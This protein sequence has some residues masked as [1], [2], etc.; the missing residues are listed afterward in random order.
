MIP[1]VRGQQEV[2]I[3]D[4]KTDKTV[5]ATYTILKQKIKNV[6]WVYVA[7]GQKACSMA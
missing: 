3:R 2:I 6:I 1:I 7:I 5:G 4:R